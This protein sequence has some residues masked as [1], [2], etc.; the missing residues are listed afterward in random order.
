MQVKGMLEEWKELGADGA[1]AK[2]RLWTWHYATAHGRAYRRSGGRCVGLAM[3]ASLIK[4]DPQAQLSALS[5]SSFSVS[6]R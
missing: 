2:A 3:L 6:C 5:S 1:A 4:A